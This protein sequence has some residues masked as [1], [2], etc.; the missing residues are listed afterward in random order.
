MASAQRLGMHEPEGMLH[1]GK[2]L[3]V[4]ETRL[5]LL[6]HSTLHGPCRHR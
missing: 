2:P 1:V 6:E 5:R 3:G 4:G